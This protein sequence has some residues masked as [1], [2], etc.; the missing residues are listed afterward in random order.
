MLVVA[1]FRLMLPVVLIEDLDLVL[2][3]DQRRWLTNPGKFVLE[4][5]QEAFV[6]LLIKCTV[7]PTGPWSITIEIKRVLDSLTQV[8]VLQ[9]LEA[10]NGVIG[11]IAWAK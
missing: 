11:G 1:N 5:I 2:Q 9:V 7:I 3:E 8:L 4:P 10:D 6:K